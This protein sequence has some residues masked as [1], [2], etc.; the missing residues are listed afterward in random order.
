[1]P[2]LECGQAPKGR[3]LPKRGRSEPKLGGSSRKAQKVPI[4]HALPNPP[5]PQ[6][7]RRVISVL[8]QVLEG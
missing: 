8:G 1:M 5:L 7:R 2:N 3:L 4:I 6:H